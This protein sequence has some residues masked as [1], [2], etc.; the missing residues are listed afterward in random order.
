MSSKG[1]RLGKYQTWT[2]YW[3]YIYKWKFGKPLSQSKRSEFTEECLV[4]T[5]IYLQDIFPNKWIGGRG[6]I[7]WR[8][9]HQTL[10]RWI[11]SLWLFQ[12]QVIFSPETLNNGRDEFSS[13]VNN[14]VENTLSTPL[15]VFY[16]KHIRY[17]MS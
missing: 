1:E 12:E 14:Y 8:V 6:H 13:I 17:L 16:L 5:R 2:Y 7:E 9:D 4:L 3:S 10:R 15:T 11:F